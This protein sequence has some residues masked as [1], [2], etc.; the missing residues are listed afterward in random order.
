MKFPRK[1]S[2]SMPFEFESNVNKN[3]VIISTNSQLKEGISFTAKF[4]LNSHPT[5][6]RTLSSCSRKRREQ[7]QKKESYTVHSSVDKKKKER[8]KM[9][10]THFP[11]CSPPSAQTQKGISHFFPS[12][13]QKQKKVSNT[14]LQ[15]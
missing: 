4:V 7:K 11:I 5:L 10:V 3:Q 8:K 9:R 2:I 13:S 15:R 12:N 6:K 14:T 1:D